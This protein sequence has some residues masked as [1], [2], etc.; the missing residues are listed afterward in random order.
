MRISDWSSD[1]CSSDLIVIT[2]VD[3]STD[4]GAKGLRRGDVIITANNRPVATQA[5]LDAQVKAVSAQGRSAILLQVLRRGPPA[6][7]LPVRLRE[8]YGQIG[9]ANVR[10]PVTN[11]HIVSRTLLEKTKNTQ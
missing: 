9:R 10:T 1:V 8:Q 11:A 7:F 2:A 5:D 4:A 6:V 3:G